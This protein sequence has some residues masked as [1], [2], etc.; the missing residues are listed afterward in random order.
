MKKGAQAT[1]LNLVPNLLK[2]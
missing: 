1:I 2:P